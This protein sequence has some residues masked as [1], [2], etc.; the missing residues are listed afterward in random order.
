MK[1]WFTGKDLMLGKTEGK[2]GSGWE[3][4]RWLENITDSWILA[5][6]RRQWR[7]EES[8]VLQFTGYRIETER[9][10]TVALQC[11]V[12]FYH[13]AKWISSMYTYIPSFLDFCSIYAITEQWVELPLIYSRFS[14]VIYFMKWKWKCGSCLVVSDLCNS[15]DYSLP[16]FAVHGTLQVKVLE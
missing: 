9:Q 1:S 2:S 12:S 16:D 14:L 6:S 4:V 11:C 13:T 5:N 15:K 7:A 10:H 8:C 3:M